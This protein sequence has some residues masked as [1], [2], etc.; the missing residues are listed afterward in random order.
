MD[1]LEKLKYP[2]GRLER[3]AP[4]LDRA[5]LDAYLAVI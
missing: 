1:D 2:V 3:P 4:P 5:A